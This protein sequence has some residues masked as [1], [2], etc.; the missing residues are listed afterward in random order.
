MLKS[1]TNDN[2]QEI[3]TEFHSQHP[4]QHSRVIQHKRTLS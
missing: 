3:K 2:K 4:T 1:V